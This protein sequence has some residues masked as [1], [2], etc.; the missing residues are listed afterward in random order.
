[1]QYVALGQVFCVNKF[2]KTKYFNSHKTV[3]SFCF[4]KLFLNFPTQKYSKDPSEEENWI[5]ELNQASNLLLLIFA[6]CL[7]LYL[8]PGV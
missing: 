7:L 3:Q 8:V 1:M 6:P 4:S 5:P 2:D